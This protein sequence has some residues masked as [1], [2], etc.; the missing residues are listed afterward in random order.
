[1]SSA[2]DGAMVI[3]SSPSGAGKTTLVKK[4]SLNRK[5]FKISISYT[6]RI[7]RINEINGK[8]YYFIDH[9]EF[10]KLINNNELLEHA[11]VFD[12]FYGTSKNKVID[13][14]QK[15]QSVIFDIDWQGASQIKE[16]KLNY[17]LIS[18]FILPPSKETLLGRLAERENNNNKFIESRMKQFEQ[19][20]L[21]W[22]NYDF[23]VINDNLEICL[24]EI[25]KVID[26]F[27]ENKNID[28]DSTKIEKHVNKL[29]I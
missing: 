26:A 28:F 4:I 21:H 25:L 10:K 29:I 6:T 19:D 20:V 2:R 11:K 5:D 24:N 22:K 14:L 17:K 3:L 7:P 18:I 9:S 27:K 12:N 13:S 15:G 23:V 1:M 8:D 16:K